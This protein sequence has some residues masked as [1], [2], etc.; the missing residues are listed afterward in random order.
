MV[1]NESSFQPEIR[2]AV[3]T[4]YIRVL[5]QS[6]SPFFFLTLVY[7]YI[8]IYRLCDCLLLPVAGSS[9]TG[10]PLPPHVTYQRKPYDRG[11][12]YL[13]HDS[14]IARWRRRR[15]C[16][17]E[18]RNIRKIPGIYRNFY[19]TKLTLARRCFRF[20]L[21]IG[22]SRVD[23][24]GLCLSLDSYIPYFRPRRQNRKLE[25]HHVA[26]SLFGSLT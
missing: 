5:V 20:Y 18:K 11:V 10:S 22:Q 6:Y 9:A 2:T 8:Y 14:V 21:R 3:R 16:L 15:Q 1:K 19:A 24:T 13:Q 4:W 23:N 17:V 25:E 26:L 12:W 7:I